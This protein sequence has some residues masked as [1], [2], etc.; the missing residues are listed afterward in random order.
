MF[1]VYKL[2]YASFFSPKWT[3]IYRAVSCRNQL[4][5]FW[6]KVHSTVYSELQ[7]MEISLKWALPSQSKAQI[8]IEL[9]YSSKTCKQM[10]NSACL[11]GPK[12]GLLP[13]S[14]LQTHTLLHHRLDPHTAPPSNT[15]LQ[16][17]SLFKMLW[18]KW[19][20]QMPLP[21]CQNWEEFFSYISNALFAA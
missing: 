11:Q 16:C 1:Y 3:Q 10:H 13:T 19:R 14:H 20:W 17:F 8:R 12:L 21:I 5:Y 9:K 7:I 2:L 15:V 4:S 6:T 18:Q